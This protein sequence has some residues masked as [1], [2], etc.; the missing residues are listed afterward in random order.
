MWV[1]ADMHI[2]TTYSDGRGSPRDVILYAKYKDL[3]VIAITDHDTFQGAVVA[4]REASKYG[5]ELIVIIGN[6]VRTDKGDILLYCYE[7]IDT[8]RDLG[9]LIDYAHEN[10]CL[11]VPAHPFDTWRH[12]IGEALYEYSGW[13]AIEVWNA[14][15]PHGAN[16]KACKAAKELGLPGLANSDAHVVEYIGVAYTLVELDELSVDSVFKAIKKKHVKPHYG[17]PPF[18][19]FLKRIAWSISRR[20]YSK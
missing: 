2:H 14:S 8:P 20:L 5:E 12:G 16:K 7:P 19:V 15:A 9:L 17:Y 11:V 6:E 13:D 3:K 1:K 4:S 10:N 18:R